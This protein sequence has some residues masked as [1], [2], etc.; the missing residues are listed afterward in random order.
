[1][2]TIDCYVSL[3]SPW[4]YLGCDRIADI[5]DRH[6][7]TVA[8]KP[9]KLTHIFEKTGG[10]PLGKR[11]PERQAYRLMELRRW[12]EYLSVPINL[13]PK[14]FR[15]NDVP[16]LQLLLAAIEQGCDGLSL[17]K[18]IGRAVWERDE[19]I[20]D[21]D[22]LAATGE[23]AGIDAK[24]ILMQASPPEIVME[25]QLELTNE[26]IERGVFGAPSYVLPTNEVFWG[27][28]RLDLLDWRLESCSR[29]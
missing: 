7:C 18:E 25:K 21:A 9:A 28:D 10:L 19:N 2:L 1:M 8:I 24:S 6:K 13:E 27:Q 16:S 4:V 12:S 17:L 20:A 3:S 22:V 23:R 29:P 5:A 15:T 26:A 11:S 14:Y